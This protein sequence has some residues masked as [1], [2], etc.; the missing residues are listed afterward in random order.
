MAKAQFEKSRNLMLKNVELH[1]LKTRPVEY[2]GEMQWEVSIRTKDPATAEFWED[3]HL[4]VKGNGTA[5]KPATEWSVSL[6]RKCKT[7]DGKDQEPI[8]IVDA[9]KQA[10]SEEDRM[11]IGNGSKGN[12]IV[13]QGHY[14]AGDGY[15]AGIM[16]SLT[17]IQV[18]DWEVYEGGGA[19]PMDF[20]NLGHADGAEGDSLF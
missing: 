15:A 5:T 17:A 11:R 2:Q 20:D 4:N 8:R 3:N 10:F 12:V 1:Y 18:T 16:T 14:A 7:R 13:W 9:E 6:K 19:D